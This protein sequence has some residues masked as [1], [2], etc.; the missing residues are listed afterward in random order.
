MRERLGP[1]FY[2]VNFQDSAE[3]DR[4]FDSD[5]RRFIDRMMRSNVITRAQFDALP[6]QRQVVSMIATM[7][8]DRT[9]G[10]A[11][12][13]EAEL[14]VYAQ[15]FAAGGFTGPINW[16]RN[17]SRNWQSSAGVAQTVHIPV[18]FLGADNDVVVSPKQIAAM[19][20]YVADLEVHVFDDCGHWLQQEA[21]AEVNA[22]MVD[23]LARRFP[24]S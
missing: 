14:D 18:L 6:P 20:E 12:L 9:R 13:E 7:K 24:A 11:L 23:W 16:Y 1:H 3:A 22:L 19:R 15:A 17:W 5:P 10:D 4:L 2:I 21:P 8:L